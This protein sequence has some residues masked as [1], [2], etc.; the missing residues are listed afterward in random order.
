[1]SY[2]RM[3]ALAFHRRSSNVTRSLT[4]QQ[5]AILGFVVVACLA[6]GVWGLFRVTGKS[7]MWRDG[8]ELTVVAVDAQDVEPGTP[9]RV[10]G[11]EAG[12]V[13]GVDYADDEVLINVRL[14]GKFRDK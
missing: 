6:I 3:A 11:V 7:G 14:D 9:V 13:V 10:R 4:H 8:Y 1:M 12:R 2:N 5:S